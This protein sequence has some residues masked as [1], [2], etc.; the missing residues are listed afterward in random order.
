MRLDKILVGSAVA[1]TLSTAAMARDYISIAGSSTVLPFATIVAE[2]MG[3]N[4]NF[5]TP[6]VESG[7]SSVGKKGVCEGI[8]T[9]FI[10]I[11]N[12]S[13]RMKT[14]ELEFC[15]ANGVKLTEIKVG[16]DGI[17][18]ASSKDGVLLNISKS[19]LGKAL[20]AKVPGP[21]GG[22]IDNPYKN[23]SDVNPDLPDIPIRV[24]GPPTTSGTR[25]SF[26]EMVNEKGYCGKDETAKAAL[27]SAGEKA[28]VCRA[29]RTD[30]AYIEAGEQDNLI[31]QKLQED[32]SAFGI[33]GFS[34]LDQNSDSLQG[35]IISGTAPTFDLIANGEYSVS[36]AL[37]FYVKHAH[38][39]VVPGIE[40]F[41]MEWTKHWGEDGVL[42]DAGMIPM[43]EEE[44]EYYMKAIK[45]LPILTAD[46]L[47]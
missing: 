38:I 13:S 36:R 42:S 25:A 10:D 35:A 19:D 21:D 40:E 34:Y 22:F 24:Y 31:V 11:G 46:M 3:N 12:A 43:P 23:W 45:E 4:P 37:Y 30:G 7:G 1:V 9:E 33:F 2:A 20:T 26:A 17:V 5:K 29:M 14:G 27:E 8:G 15:E 6:V 39:G 41:L 16:Y 44:R 18:V 32:P 28:K 47:E